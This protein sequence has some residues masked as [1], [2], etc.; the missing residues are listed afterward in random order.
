MALNLQTPANGPIEF[1]TAFC[2]GRA[3]Q[4]ALNR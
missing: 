1:N 4:K 3:R 2:R